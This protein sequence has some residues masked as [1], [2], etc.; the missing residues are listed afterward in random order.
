MADVYVKT[1]SIGEKN[2]FK[3]WRP[4]SESVGGEGMCLLKALKCHK[5]V[6]GATHCDSKPRVVA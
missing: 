1:D 4:V 2:A 3:N 6:T 5:C